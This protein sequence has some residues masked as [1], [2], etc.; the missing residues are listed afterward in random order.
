MITDKA[1]EAMGVKKVTLVIRLDLSRVFDNI[2]HTTLL[3][4]QQELGV[5]HAS[6]DWF[7]SY[8]PFETAAMR[9][10]PQA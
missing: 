1:L 2:D 5:S 3:A 6:L 4:K 10:R 9:L 7:K 8:L